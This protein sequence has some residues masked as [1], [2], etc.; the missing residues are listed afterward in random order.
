MPSHIVFLI[1]FRLI[2]EESSKT[3]FLKIFVNGK[4]LLESIVLYNSNYQGA[5]EWFNG[6]VQNFLTS[7]KDHQKYWCNLEESINNFLKY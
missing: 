5:A 1:D 2:K 4:V 3:I 6:I 7:A